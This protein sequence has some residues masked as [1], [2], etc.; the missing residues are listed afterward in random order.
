MGLGL[1]P[2]G[3]EGSRKGLGGEGDIFIYLFSKHMLS[4]RAYYAECQAQRQALIESKTDKTLVLTTY[5]S[6]NQF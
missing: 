6:D 2:V 1:N 3:S 5:A 4:A